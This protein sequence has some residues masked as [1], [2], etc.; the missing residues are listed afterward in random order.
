MPA[1]KIMIIRHGEKP[2]D[3]D[4]PST[5]SG[6]AAGVSPSGTSDPEELIVRGWQ[7]SGALVRFFAPHDKSPIADSRLATPSTIFASGLGKH[8]QSLRPQHTVLELAN[9]LGIDLN[10]DHH[11]GSELDLAKAAIAAKGPVLISW[12]PVSTALAW[13]SFRLGLGL[14]S[15]TCGQMDV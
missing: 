12:E 6:E 10:L 3:K 7:R 5:N 9:S 14:R 2:A 11:K 13:I 15:F 1:N 4:K 8:S